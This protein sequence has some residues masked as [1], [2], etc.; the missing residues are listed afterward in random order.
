MNEGGAAAA[1][2]VSVNLEVEATGLNE[3][4]RL[5][6]P[7]KKRSRL[8]LLVLDDDRAMTVVHGMAIMIAYCRSESQWSG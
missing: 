7:L 3:Y 2:V 5:S 4:L 1:G 6:A 8:R